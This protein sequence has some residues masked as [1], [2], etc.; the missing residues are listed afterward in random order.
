MWYMEFLMWLSGLR[1][2]LVSMRMQVRSPA[3]LSWVWIHPVFG[4]G[5]RCSSNPTLQL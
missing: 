3:L 1:I 2:R 5:C 4:V